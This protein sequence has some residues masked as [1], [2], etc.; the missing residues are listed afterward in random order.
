MGS[1]LDV[2]ESIGGGGGFDGGSCDG[3]GLIQPEM[4]VAL[5]GN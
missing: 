5:A 2:F 1:R 4:Q 3:L